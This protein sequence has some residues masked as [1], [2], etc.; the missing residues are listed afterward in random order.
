[1]II[2]PDSDPLFEISASMLPAGVCGGDSWELLRANDRLLSLL[3]IPPAASPGEFFRQW[4]DGG[5]LAPLS[6]DDGADTFDSAFFIRDDG[7]EFIINWQDSVKDDKLLRIFTVQP[8]PA[9]QLRKAKECELKEF[10]SILDFIHDGIWIID[11]N[12][13]TLRI[14]RAMERIAGIRADEVVGRHVSEPLRE[15]RFKTCVTLRAL[16]TRHTVTLFDDYSNGKRCLNTSTPI[17]NSKGDVWRVIAAIRDITELETLQNRLSDLEVEALAYKL[18]ARDLEDAAHNSFIGRSAAL[19]KV[20]QDIGKAARSEAVTLILGETGTGKSLAAK[21]IH[22][23]GPRAQK[24]FV[25]LNC[26]AIPDT[27]MESE[28]FGYEKGAF[29]GASRNGKP[30]LLELASGGTLLL[31]EIGELSLPLQAKLLH[32]LDGNSI[33]RV[34]GT[35]PIPVN[36]RIIAA[37]NRSLREMVVQGRF[38][39]DLFY[40]LRVICIEIP[41]LRDRIEDILLLASHFLNK[42]G[43]KSGK[44]KKLDRRAERMFLKYAWPGNTR[45]LQSVIQSLF[46]LC[47]ND[48][49]VPADLPSYMREKTENQ[50]VSPLRGLSEA[51]ESLEKEMI[52]RALAETGSTYKA[53]KILRVSQS[54]VVRKAKKYGIV[55]QPSRR[56]GIM[57][58]SPSGDSDGAD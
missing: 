18:R 58:T 48:V 54:S 32:V 1:M 38:R 25:S 8:L 35:R 14:N 15:G 55:C 7:S 24:P 13:V 42:L 28:L 12:G 5:D 29:T 56:D 49:I 51:I 21:T 17:F 36:A 37:T 52:A 47:E 4:L 11:G 53:A 57:W 31:D 16:R 43:K 6:G 45:E 27:L 3:R 39:E 10:D 50:A 44:S 26:G 19:R 41:P 23:L 2:R 34:G 20:V 9:C 46:T 22:E 40:R 30:G 33:Y